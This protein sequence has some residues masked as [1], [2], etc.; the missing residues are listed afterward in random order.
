MRSEFTLYKRVI[1]LI[2][3]VF[4]PVLTCAQGQFDYLE[5][6]AWQIR[7]N[8]GLGL[9]PDQELLDSGTSG[10]FD[11]GPLVL[12]IGA[13]YRVA[14]WPNHHLYLGLDAGFMS[15][16]SD[17]PG[18]FT[19]PTSDVAYLLPSLALYRGGHDEPRL[20]LRA[21]VGRYRVEFSELVDTTSINRTFSA[22]EFGYF[23]G[24]GFDLPLNFGSGLNSITLDSRAHFVDFGEVERL[25]FLSQN[26]SGPIWTL[27]LGWSRRF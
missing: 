23:V 18:R 19:S 25:G 1:L 14:E 22:S 7:L 2:S 16:Q 6:P 21:G 27:Q 20:N 12:E 13:D 8:F 9:W 17:I 5:N 3:F 24:L 11:S 15:T 4:I 26:L 10:E